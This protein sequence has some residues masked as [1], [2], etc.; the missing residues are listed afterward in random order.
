LTFYGIA[1][2]RLAST[3]FGEVIE[4]YV[5]RADAEQ[6]L[7]DVLADEP[8]WVGEVGVVSIDF[9]LSPQ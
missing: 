7:K 1:D 5:N 2:S 9:P 4:I 6:A 8:E 3:E